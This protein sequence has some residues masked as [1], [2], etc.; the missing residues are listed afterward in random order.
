MSGEQI[1]GFTVDENG[2]FTRDDSH[3]R[4]H[5]FSGSDDGRTIRIDYK[6]SGEVVM[7][8]IR[9]A[10]FYSGVMR[11]IASHYTQ[12]ISFGRDISMIRWV[13]EEA[14][15]C[16]QTWHTKFRMVLGYVTAPELYSPELAAIYDEYIRKNTG[17]LF[18]YSRWFIDEHDIYLI[19]VKHIFVVSKP[20]KA[21]INTA[22]TE[23]KRYYG[24][25]QSTEI[26]RILAENFKRLYP[27]SA[28]EEDL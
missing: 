7:P 4:E 10:D 14:F 8:T 13:S 28:L 19:L 5:N 12:G 16:K 23:A 25:E 17:R 1:L 3:V 6:P 20:S 24:A 9:E 27:K 18:K 11:F 2:V 15:K 21:A 22:V 26:C